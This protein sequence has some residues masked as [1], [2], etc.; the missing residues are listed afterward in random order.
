MYKDAIDT[1]SESNKPKLANELI[2]YFVEKQDAECFCACLYTC[3]DLIEPSVALELAWRNGFI[4]FVMPYMIQYL[5]DSY[6]KSQSYEERLTKI[7]KAKE[8]TEEINNAMSEP[9]GTAN[10]MGGRL[11]IGSSAFNQQPMGATGMPGMG[12]PPPMGGGLGGPPAPMGN[13]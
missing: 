11:A 9:F 10:G 2:R 3:Y 4:D 5:S 6:E 13:M 1:A 8:S 7:E 12:G